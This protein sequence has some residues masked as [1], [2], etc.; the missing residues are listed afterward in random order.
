MSII[1]GL[2][3]S[4]ASRVVGAHLFANHA[5]SAGIGTAQSLI[6]GLGLRFFAGMGCAFYIS[7]DDFRAAANTF[8]KSVAGMFGGGV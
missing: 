3:G 4:V 6:E 1:L 7:N 2:L 8:V 5:A